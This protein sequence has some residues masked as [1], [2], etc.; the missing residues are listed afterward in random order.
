MKKRSGEESPD[1]SGPDTAEEDRRSEDPFAGACRPGYIWGRTISE[2][3][4]W[5]KE[6]EEEEKRLLESLKSKEH[7]DTDKLKQ[8]EEEQKQ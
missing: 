7:P 4:K 3:E 5:R 2:D 1:S 8:K 6:K